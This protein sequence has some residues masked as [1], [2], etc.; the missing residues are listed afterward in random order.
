MMVFFP[1]I[2][3]HEVEHGLILCENEILFWE[4]GKKNGLWVHFMSKYGPICKLTKD[5]ADC[6]FISQ[7]FEVS[8]VKLLG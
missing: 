8:F 4:T 6:G 2:T 3:C 5:R 7:N 1:R